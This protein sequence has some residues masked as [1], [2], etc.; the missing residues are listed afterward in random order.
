MSK[1]VPVL[2]Y[3]GSILITIKVYALENVLKLKRDAMSQVVFLDEAM[4]V[5]RRP[6]LLC[7]AGYIRPS[8][9]RE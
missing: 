2:L 8:D 5:S 3:P 1:C 7:V 6:I 9:S 4:K